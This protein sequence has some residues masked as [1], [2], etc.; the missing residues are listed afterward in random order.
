MT[1][2]LLAGLA[3]LLIY[4]NRE[5][6]APAATELP[7]RNIHDSVG[8]VGMETCR[9]C[10]QEIYDSFIQTGMGRSFGSARPERS[11]ATY[12]PH[13]LVY[14]STNN[15]HYFPYFAGDTLF[16]REFRLGPMGDTLHNRLEQVA[17]IIGSG[18]HTNSHILN[19]NGYAYQAPITFYTQDGRWD[20]AP[21]YEEGNERFSRFL[22]SECL[23]CH[24]DYP[25]P[26]PGS[27]NK[28]AAM[29]EGIA[30]ERC[31]GA[32]ELHVREKLA[33]VTVDTA[34]GPDYSIVNP[35]RLPRDRQMDLC[36]RC[37]LQGIALLEE[38]RTFYDFRP[39]MQLHEVLNVYLPRFTDSHDKFI[40][41]SQADRLR[42]SACYQQ[43]EMTCI[44]C[45]NPHQSVKTLSSAHFNQACQSCHEAA[46]ETICSADAADLQAVNNDCVHC[47]MPPSGSADIPHVNITDHYISRTNVRGTGPQAIGT[48]PGK[49]LGLEILTKTEAT[50][51]DM[52]RAYIALYDKYAEEAYILDSAAYY[53]ARV[54]DDSPLAR[55]T[56]VHYAFARGDYARL[57]ELAPQFEPATT[58]GWTA[59]RLGEGFY[60]EGQYQRALDWFT[61]ATSD[62][63]YQLDFLEKEAAALIDLQ[64][65]PEAITILRR[66]LAE[67]PRRP[68]ALLNLGYVQALRSDFAQALTYY[69]RAIALDPDYEQALL[70]KAAI[71]LATSRVEE[72]VGL[73]QRVIRINPQNR[74]AIQILAQIQ[75]NG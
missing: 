8:Y 1:Y 56:R 45:H 19:V 50:A 31:H 53:L 22:T 67:H 15:L 59:Y 6:P 2:I 34:L 52:A 54:T 65:Y 3:G 21:G 13:A 71:L 14:D 60:Y 74:Q 51:L 36:Q 68:A 63:P 43:S 30:C 38:D 40:M 75:S 7:W 61:R 18:H 11:D 26:V 41:A 46:D 24:N 5:L 27:L 62:M 37:H 32:G 16:I 33:G 58:D 29:P 48:E 42:M 35:R 69:D 49:F 44:T 25:T 55:S 72:A 39:G 28:Y 4:C 47:H 73:L 12:G 20:L 64:R 57:R 70:N 66:I 10:H 9:S 23:T 17:Y